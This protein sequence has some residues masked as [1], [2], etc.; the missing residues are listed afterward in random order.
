MRLESGKHTQPRTDHRS[1]DGMDQ[2]FLPQLFQKPD[3]PVQHGYRS[4][5]ELT[6]GNGSRVLETGMGNL[7]PISVVVRQ[8]PIG[9]GKLPCIFHDPAKIKVQREPAGRIGAV[10][11]GKSGVDMGIGLHSVKSLVPRQDLVGPA[12]KNLIEVH[13][14]GD[15]IPAAK[16]IGNQLSVK[17]VVDHLIAGLDD[18]T[19]S[20]RVQ[21]ADLSV[22]NGAGLFDGGHG[23][24]IAGEAI[25]PLL[26]R[27]VHLQCPKRLSTVIHVVR[28]QQFPQKITVFPHFVSPP[29]RAE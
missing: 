14:N 17:P 24:Y 28:Q 21:H 2:A 22:G 11:G 13:V 15:Q 4:I 8:L 29:R 3:M 25:N 26:R 10:A 27:R 6:D 7:D 5:I 20:V 16:H 12:G 9:V 19:A 18:G 23:E 1:P